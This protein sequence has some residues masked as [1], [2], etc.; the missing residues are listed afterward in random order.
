MG[1]IGKIYNL[2]VYICALLNHINEFK[3]LFGKLIPLGNY[4]RWNNWFYMLYVI[5][6]TE[7]FNM[8][9]NYTEVY[10]NK[11]IIDKRDELTPF[12]ITLYY[13]IK[14]FLFIFESAILFHKQ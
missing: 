4:I 8:L 7:V 3:A 14:Q 10:I 5:L 9:W 2:V 11:G 6:K 1:V 13:I 12:D